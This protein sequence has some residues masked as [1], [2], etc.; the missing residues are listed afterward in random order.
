MNRLARLE[1]R[2]L[3]GGGS[4]YVA[5]TARQRLLGLAWLRELP[6]GAALLI[7]RCASVHTCWMRFSIDVV[8]LDAGG[9]PLRVA[10]RIQPWRMARCP[11]ADAVIETG[12]GQADRLNYRAAVSEASSS[13]AVTRA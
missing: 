2:P 5:R 6:A 4:L 12:A 1:C 11:G 7:P 3:P 8:F 10:E 9:R 13:P